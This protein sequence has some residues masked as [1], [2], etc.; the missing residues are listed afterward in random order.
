MDNINQKLLGE[1]RTLFVAMVNE[2][3]VDKRKDIKIEINDL[4]FRGKFDYNRFVYHPMVVAK[5]AVG[6]V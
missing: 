4:C 6:K 2:T 5:N 1:A 3:D